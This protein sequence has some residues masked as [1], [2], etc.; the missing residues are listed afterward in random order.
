MIKIFYHVNENGNNI[1]HDE[2]SRLLT[3]VLRRY[4]VYDDGADV[5]IRS[6]RGKPY[7]AQ[8]PEIEFSVTHTGNVWICA[9]C[10][11]DKDECSFNSGRQAVFRGGIPVGIDAEF[12]DRRVSRPEKVVEKYF[13]EAEKK[14]FYNGDN[15]ICSSFEK[16]YF[17]SEIAGRGSADLLC[18]VENDVIKNNLKS[19]ADLEKIKNKCFLKLWTMKEA[20]LKMLG[21]GITDNAGNYCSI[22]GTGFCFAGEDSIGMIEREISSSAG[23]KVLISLCLGA[24][25]FREYIGTADKKLIFLNKNACSENII[26]V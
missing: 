10:V 2:S 8:A 3:A 17:N 13:S 14:C 26:V 6:E 4:G 12:A 20:Y 16:E 18:G 24:D 9:V 7:A 19:G 25:D 21:V 11:H 15:D 23:R 5:I 1:K 22:N